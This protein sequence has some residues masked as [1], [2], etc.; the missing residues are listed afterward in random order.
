MK[1]LTLEEIEPQM[2]VRYVPMHGNDDLSHPSVEQGVVSSKN[3]H[4]AFV[5]FNQQVAKFGW[6]GTTSQACSA[7]DL[8]RA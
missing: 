7:E 6:D 8:I 2:K 1:R 4:F 3:D 5:K